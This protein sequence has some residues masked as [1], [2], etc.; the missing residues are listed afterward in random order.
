MKSPADV[1]SASSKAYN[2]LP[3]IDCPFYDRDALVT[4]CGRI[5]MV[6]EEDQ[7]LDRQWQDRDWE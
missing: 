3:D 4:N 2:G 1:Y 6:P 7:H 5:C